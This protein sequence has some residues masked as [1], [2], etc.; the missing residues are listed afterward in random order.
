MKDFFGTEIKIGDIVAFTDP[1][2][3]RKTLVSGQVVSIRRRFLEIELSDPWYNE[4]VEISDDNQPTY[5]LKKRFEAVVVSPN[6]T[7]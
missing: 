6:K 7:K 2:A 5:R 3:S 4:D 1:E